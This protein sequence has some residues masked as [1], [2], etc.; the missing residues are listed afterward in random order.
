MYVCTLWIIDHHKNIGYKNGKLIPEELKCYEHLYWF[1]MIN[2]FDNYFSWQRS[3]LWGSAFDLGVE[4][5]E[6]AAF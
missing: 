5:S 4:V 2:P 1:V 6:S 3:G